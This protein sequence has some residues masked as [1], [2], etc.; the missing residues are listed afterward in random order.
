VDAAAMDAGKQGEIAA[1][2]RRYAQWRDREWPGDHRYDAWVAKPI[3]NARLLPFGL[4]DR[5]VPAFAALF[6]QAERQ[7][8]AFHA[9][10]RELARES[11]AQR[12]QALRQL[13][14]ASCADGN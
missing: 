6:R 9:S 4:Y 1:F 10:V 8:P 13:C 12:E 7:W 5:W 11:A 14:A 2:R 3:N